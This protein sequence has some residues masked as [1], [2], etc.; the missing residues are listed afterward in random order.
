MRIRLKTCSYRV[1]QPAPALD[2]IVTRFARDPNT[3]RMYNPPDVCNACDRRM[4][5]IGFGGFS[6]AMTVSSSCTSPPTSNSLT[7]TPISSSRTGASIRTFLNGDDGSGEPMDERE[8]F[9]FVL[10]VRVSPE[11]AGSFEFSFD[12][13]AK[14]GPRRLIAGELSVF[15]AC[16]FVLT[17][18]L[19]PL[20]RAE[21]G[22]KNF[23]NERGVT[24]GGFFC[25]RR[26]PISEAIEGGDEGG[27]CEDGGRT[28]SDRGTS[29]RPWPVSI[30]S[31]KEKDRRLHSRGKRRREE[32]SRKI[33]GWGYAMRREFVSA[34][35]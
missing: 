32:V 3:L 1:N 25:F 22:V 16:R 21:R 14:A 13:L 9:R 34:F 35:V 10:G 4:G 15:N 33:E 2:L 19:L 27:S 17:P 23:R 5:A 29:G 8:S 6:S 12:V 18:P 30:V 28:G 7:G 20:L 24:G 11:G 26:M 31:R